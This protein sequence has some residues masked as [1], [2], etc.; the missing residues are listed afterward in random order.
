MVIG[1]TGKYCAGKNTVVKILKTYSLPEIDVDAVGHEV[2]EQEKQA[3][4]AEF[5]P[6][7]IGPAGKID[8][9]RLGDMVFARK[10]HM[11]RLEKILHPLMKVRIRR[12]VDAHKDGCVINAALL[13]K[14]DLHSL[15]DFVI[16]VKARF[17][18]RLRRA[19]HRDRLGFGRALQRFFAQ[20]QIFPKLTRPAVDIYYVYNNGGVEGL[21]KRIAGLVAQRNRTEG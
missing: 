18:T 11:R 15:C 10:K 17:F 4:A 16:M 21:K 13:F 5:G 3:V 19:V 2:L 14:L 6:S 20:G 1:V 8:R 9:R 7:I 12:F